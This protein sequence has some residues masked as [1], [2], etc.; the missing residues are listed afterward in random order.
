[1]PSLGPNAEPNVE[2]HMRLELMTQRS[3]A[4]L[5]SRVGHSTDQATQTY[6]HTILKLK[7]SVGI[8]MRSHNKSNQEYL[9]I[10]G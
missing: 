4:K 10:C 1:M 3:R 8:T 6:Q 9:S 2:P 7:H 5:I